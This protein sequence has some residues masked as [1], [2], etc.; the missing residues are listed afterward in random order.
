MPLNP[1]NNLYIDTSGMSRSL[2]VQGDN[3]VTHSGKM[4][5]ND[6]TI[7]PLQKHD[8]AASQLSIY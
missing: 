2:L 4:I 3:G 6:Y 8:R 7:I 5:V 1:K